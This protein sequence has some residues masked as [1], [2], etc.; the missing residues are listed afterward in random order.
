MDMKMAGDPILPWVC[1]A[2]IAA[3]VIGGCTRP[4]EASRQMLICRVGSVETYR[5][6][7]RRWY[8]DGGGWHTNKGPDGPRYRQ[9]MLESC[10]TLETETQ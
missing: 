7:A 5:Q 9:S 6:D 10:R 4:Q 8:S 3:A 2:V 1:F